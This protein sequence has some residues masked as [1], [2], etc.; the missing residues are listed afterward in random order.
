[1]LARLL[2]SDSLRAAIGFAA[3]GAGFAAGNIILAKVLTPASF[4]VVSLAL[5]F[6]QLGLN[7]GPLGLEVVTNRHRFRASGH[8]GFLV[9]RS[10]TIIAAILAVIASYYYQ[11]PNAVVALLFVMAIACAV[12]RIGV[13]LF[14]GENRLSV[15]MVLLQI[16]NYV[17]LLAALL[18]VVLSQTNE[19]FVV[20]VITVGYVAS[21]IV[22][23]WLAH[24]RL[25][26]GR[27]EVDPRLALKEGLAAL[28]IG[29]AVQLLWQIERLAIPKVG[30][31]EML[32]TYAVL[33]AVAGSPFR[34]IQI[35]TG[36]SLLPR[37]RSVTT[38][39]AA[40][41]VLVRE[42]STALLMIAASIIVVLVA[43]PFIF[44]T[45][46]EGKYPIGTNLI[47]ASFV[48]GVAKVCESFSTTVV[49]ACGTRRHLA[50]ISV[51]GWLCVAVAI[52]GVIVG[53]RFGLVGIL[54]G[55]GAAW[56]LLA[57]S[58][59]Y[60]ATHCF[61]ARFAPTQPITLAP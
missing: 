24:H 34:M 50:T 36:F 3:G 31:I 22:G 49:S 28:G 45:L 47:I 13:A 55:V 57:A 43:A 54:Y 7:F 56:A 58:G 10:S 29:V 59:G 51:L 17:L 8:L 25:L 39:G 4:G 42:S 46:L 26:A 37:L 33:A 44:N 11:L 61:R 5:V 16:H 27:Q 38:A 30:S 21:M 32:G 9:F 12:N 1:M 15:A 2:K 19:V 41:A 18:A 60:L 52:G 35:G 6:N 53:S 48:I 23:W 20:S 14:Q 40:R